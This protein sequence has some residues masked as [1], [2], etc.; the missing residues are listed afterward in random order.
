MSF[1]KLDRWLTP[2]TN[3]AV[4]A[5][6]LLIVVELKQNQD[7][8]ELEQELALLDS[9]QTDFASL[10][11]LRN[12]VIEDPELAQLFLDGVSGAELSEADALRFRYLCQNWFWSAVMMHDRSVRLGREGYPEST[13]E[14]MRSAIKAPGLNTCW[15]DTKSLYRL[16]GFQDF[17][18]AVDAP[19]PSPGTDRD[20]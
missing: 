7:T 10:S 8:L 13:I 1:E 20:E 2:I 17:V 16:W 12:Q 15:Q 3:L 18:N 14:W 5:G 11:E 9:Q 6:L 19:G 4:L